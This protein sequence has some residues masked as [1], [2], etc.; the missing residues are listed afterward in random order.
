M[1]YSYELKNLITREKDIEKVKQGRKTAVRRSNRFGDVGDRW[2]LDG[3]TLE[4]VNVYQQQL[5]DV[6]DEHAK[7]EGYQ[8]LE[9]YKQAITNIHQEA[10]WN[11]KLT[12]W[13]HEFKII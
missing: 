8:H 12:V 5:A 3:V 6:T 4:L 10:I 13:V 1:T 9:D 2:D 11:P 7:Q